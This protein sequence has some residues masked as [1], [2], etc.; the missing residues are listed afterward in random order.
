MSHKQAAMDS[1][2]RRGWVVVGTTFITLSLVIGVWYS[3][4]VF[5][6]AFLREFGWS[7][8]LVAG[9]FSVFVLVHGAV[10]P[11]VGWLAGRV[12]PRRVIL[13]GGCVLGCGLLLTAETTAWWHLYLAFGGV[14]AVGLTMA[15]WLP[16]V[17]LVRGWF[18][19]R[20]GTAMGITSAGI[21]V[22]IFTLVPFTQILI[23]GVGWRWA[24]RVLAV[25]IL[26]WVLPATARLVRE[27]P[28]PEVSDP[29]ST[30]QSL[31]GLSPCGAQWTLATAVRDWH[32]WALAGV[33]FTGNF[34]TQMLLV[35]QVAFL[36]DHGV[37]PLA[38]AW[39]GGLAGLVSIAG[40]IWCGAFSDRA[41]REVAYSLAFGCIVAGLGAL[42]L[43]GR[44][45]SSSLPYVY[46]ILIGLGY[47]GIAPIAP[48]AASDLFSGPAFSTIFGTVYP[49]LCLGIASGAW[50]AGWIFDGTGGYALAFWIALL[51]AVS[52][53]A[54]LWIVAPR[55]PNPAPVRWSS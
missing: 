18:P 2:A 6:V 1:E 28:P 19:G 8:S 17:V 51:M 32:F 15:G 27:S 14:T 3:Y 5:L 46:A 20:F 37:S 7:R 25:L 54:L 44:Y 33:F 22:G 9:S 11:I 24:F 43:A 4:S 42:V 21:G 55:R 10:S 49:A 52:S 47:G 31:P 48:A 34:V 50:V 23:D 40:K 53:P 39:V 26:G 29:S 16:A 12:G 36:V 45:P 30:R 35:H 13:A 38:A 41:G